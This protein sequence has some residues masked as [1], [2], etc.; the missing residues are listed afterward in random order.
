MHATNLNK[1]QNHEESRKNLKSS[2]REGEDKAVPLN[3][4]PIDL[5]PGFEYA[6]IP[7]SEDT[8]K[9]ATGCLTVVTLPVI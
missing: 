9:Q 8:S 2:S 6:E 1:W 3:G 7:E 5:V 4:E